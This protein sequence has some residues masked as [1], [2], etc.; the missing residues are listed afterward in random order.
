MAAACDTATD[1]AK[2][3]GWM[4]LFSAA[5][6]GGRRFFFAFSLTGARICPNQLS[7]HHK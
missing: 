7:A 4:Q 3:P 6:F 2:A 1:E 5:I